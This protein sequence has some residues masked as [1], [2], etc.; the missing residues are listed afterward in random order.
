MEVGSRQILMPI[1]HP[2]LY[3]HENTVFLLKTPGI[4]AN[5][6]S[7]ITERSWATPPHPWRARRGKW[8]V[9]A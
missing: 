4:S 5:S 1:A 3:P 2:F 9:A 7:P 6:K 8:G